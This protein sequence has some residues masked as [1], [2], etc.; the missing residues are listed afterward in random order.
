MEAM[1]AGLDQPGEE[2]RV[3]CRHCVDEY[4][5]AEPVD[6]DEQE[7]G[8]VGGFRRFGS[9]DQPL[10]DPLTPGVVVVDVQQPPDGDVHDAEPECDT[11]R[12]PERSHLDSTDDVGGEPDEQC[13]EDEREQTERQQHDGE[14]D[15]DHER[16]DH[17]VQNRQHRNRGDSGPE[18]FDGQP[19]EYPA[20]EQQRQR[21]RHA[22]D[23]DADEAPR[24]RR[25]FDRQAE[26]HGGRHHRSG[27]SGHGSHLPSPQRC[28]A[29]CQFGHEQP[30]APIRSTSDVYAASVSSLRCVARQGAR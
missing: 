9:A 8:H 27:V 13:V 17:C 1:G 19:F 24:R 30:S 12:R 26:R 7:A 25:S 3:A 2:R 6:L 18:P 11:E 5:V 16:P 21:L 15:T 23:D 28:R 4:I 29:N 20:E 22:E 10:Y 14:C